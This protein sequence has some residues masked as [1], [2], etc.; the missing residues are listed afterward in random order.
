MIFKLQLVLLKRSKDDMNLEHVDN[1]LRLFCYCHFVIR[2][3]RSRSTR[4]QKHLFHAPSSQG[5]SFVPSSALLC[6]RNLVENI[7][8]T[9][10]LSL[11]PLFH[12]RGRRTPSLWVTG[13]TCFESVDIIC[14]IWPIWPIRSWYTGTGRL[15]KWLQ[16]PPPLLSPVS[17]RF[18]FVFVLSQFSGPNYLG[19]WNRLHSGQSKPAGDRLPAWSPPLRRWIWSCQLFVSKPLWLLLVEFPGSYQ[20]E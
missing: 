19:A 13:T 15:K 16:A 11:I 4:S 17:L 2:Q 12:A 20:L 14:E 1:S 18:I 8:P 6:A 9:E 7:L 5:R 3:D 10:K